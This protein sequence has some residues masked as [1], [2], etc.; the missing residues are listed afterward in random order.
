MACSSLVWQAAAYKIE[1]TDV[2]CAKASIDGL[3]GQPL[4]A[5]CAFKHTGRPADGSPMRVT[6]LF[7]DEEKAA[8]ALG[9]L[10][11]GAKGAGGG[12]SAGGSSTPRKPTPVRCNQIA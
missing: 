5:A 6:L 10:Q 4:A 1:L 7:K 2:N 8:K 12:A 11:G 3:L 9:L